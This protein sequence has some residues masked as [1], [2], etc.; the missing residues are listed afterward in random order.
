MADTAPIASL[1]L[2]LEDI[3]LL[4]SR[5]TEDLGRD[6]CLLKFG[7]IC[8]N[9]TVILDDEKRR[10]GHLARVLDEFDREHIAF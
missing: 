8:N 3:D 6:R 2:V 10:V 9:R 1:V 4:T 7:R 5:L